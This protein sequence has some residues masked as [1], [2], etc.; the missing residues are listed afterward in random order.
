MDLIKQFYTQP[1]NDDLL[2]QPIDILNIV[3]L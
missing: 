2:Q 3:R 1:T